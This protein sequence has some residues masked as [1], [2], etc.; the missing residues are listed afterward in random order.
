M[1]SVVDGVCATVNSQDNWVM[2][3]TGYM[4]LLQ[5]FTFDYKI[6]NISHL[7][8]VVNLIFRHIRYVLADLLHCS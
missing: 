1:Q 8:N 5:V 4:N 2:C 6:L 7:S 3:A